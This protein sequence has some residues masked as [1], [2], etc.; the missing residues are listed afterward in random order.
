MIVDSHTHLWQDP[1]QLGPSVAAA[2][3]RK[4]GERWAPLDASP[5]AHGEA[6]EPVD[7]AFVLGFRSRYLDASVPNELL[8]EHVGRQPERLVGFAGLD[9][10]TPGAVNEVESLPG[11]GLSGVT[12]DPACQDFHPAD[13]RAMQ[14]YEACGGLGLP[15][16]VQ[17][18]KRMAE[19]AKLEY[20]RPYLFDEVARTFADL[21][22][23]IGG[24]GY[25]W[26]EETYALIDKH[27][28]VYTD[29]A[30]LF[31]RPWQLYNALLQAYQLGVTDRL[32]FGSGFPATA[33]GEAIETIYSLNRYA[34]GT[35][36]PSIPREK[37][38]LIVERDTLGALGLP[39]RA[40][41]GGGASPRPP[42]RASVA[43][44][45]H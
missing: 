2:L 15:I 34:H 42:A 36:L 1:E 6:I 10:T 25:P 41:A 45:T 5:R 16:V 44:E 23:V 27:A 39:R 9:P 32:L 26:A 28:N 21:K 8:A 43:E 31:D 37:L 30:G 22:L 7:V 19:T 38:R 4:A 33:P 35:A 24:L 17:S 29:L 14:F 13:T 3:R 40:G 18:S 20:G 12:V 11:M